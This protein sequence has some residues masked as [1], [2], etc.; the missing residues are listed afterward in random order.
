MASIVKL[1]GKWRALIRR[2]GHKS[3]SKWFDT[4]AKAAAW[5]ADIEGQ[6]DDGVVQQSV[7]TKDTIGQL[8]TKYRKLRSKVKHF[9][10]CHFNIS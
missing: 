4:K 2:K 6:I 5:A 3:I 9:I 7:L 10:V 8:I 1:N